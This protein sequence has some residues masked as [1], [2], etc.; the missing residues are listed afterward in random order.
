MEACALFTLGRVGDVA[1]C[2]VVHGGWTGSTQA[3]KF[4]SVLGFRNIKIRTV[5]Y[6]FLSAIEHSHLLHLGN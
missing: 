5:C 2:G 3:Q 6:S 1:R 4:L